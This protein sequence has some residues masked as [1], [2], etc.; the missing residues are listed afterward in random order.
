[1]MKYAVLLATLVLAGCTSAPNLPPTD[2]IVAIKPIESGIIASSEQHSYRFFRKGMPQEYQRY[3][4]FYERFH[5]QA[6]GVRVNFVVEDHEV[7]A[8]YLVVMDKRKLDASQ[9]AELIKQY[10]ATPIDNDRL[11]VVF[12]ATGFWSKSHAPELA[13][14]YRLEQPVV[15]SI[16]DKTQTIS[17]LGAIALIPLVPLFPLYMMYGCARGPCV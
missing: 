15:V 1:M 5:R 7:T 10:K 12:N 8:E 2:T 13:A 4:T 9:Q 17:T 16:N 11:G 14:P 6:S 3:K